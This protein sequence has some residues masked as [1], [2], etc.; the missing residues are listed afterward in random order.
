MRLKLLIAYDGSGYSGWQ[1]QEK[2]AAPPTI[3]GEV[4]RALA[5]LYGCKIR[6]FGSGRTDA[7]VHAWG[8]VAHCDI[9]DAK[10]SSG[11]WQHR[12]NALLPRNIRILSAKLVPACFHARKDALSKTYIYQLWP[13]PHF[14]P[15]MLVSHFWHCGPLDQPAM[16]EALP[17]LLGEMDFASLRN[18]GTDVQSSI[19]KIMA[20]N[21]EELQPLAFYPPHLP[22]LRLAVT[23]NGFLKQMVRNIVGLLVA[24]GKGRIK[25][26]D[27]PSILAARDRR[28]L[29]S[30]T[31]PAKGLILAKVDYG[32]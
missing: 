32:P 24:C 23:A 14:I 25:P 29:T 31:A 19:R 11:D 9:P 28:S 18:V 2:P 21:L 30:A 16:L 27:I 1:I 22:A 15:P 5:T 26:A 6:V 7:G 8:Q 12:L 20:L 3:Q 17:T 13:E 10:A 4:E